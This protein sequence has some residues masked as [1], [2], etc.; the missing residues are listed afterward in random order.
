MHKGSLDTRP[1]LNTYKFLDYTFINIWYL[2]LKR[3]K[4][5]CLAKLDFANSKIICKQKLIIYVINF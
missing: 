1:D 5:S 2:Q 3:V 4:S